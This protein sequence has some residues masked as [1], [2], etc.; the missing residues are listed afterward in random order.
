MF[1]TVKIQKMT[2]I[3]EKIPDKFDNIYLIPE[4]FTLAEAA[5]FR[6]L[7]IQLRAIIDDESKQKDFCGLPVIKTSDAAENFN[8]RTILIIL[9]QKP[10]PII[11][12]IF[13]LKAVG[14]VWTIPAFVM[15][16]E[17]T[18]PIYD[19][20]TLLKIV[21]QYEEDGI[22]KSGINFNE[23]AERF[24]RGLTTML[25]PHFQNF[26][27][28]LWDSNRYFK[29]TYTFDDT[30]IVIQG[31][32]VYENNYTAE[33]FKLYRSIYPNVPIIV[34]TWKDEATDDFRRECKEN[35]IV[36]L[37]NEPPKDRGYANLN[38]QLKSSLEGVKYVKESITAKFVLKT[39]SDQRIN[40]FEFL[41]HFKNLLKTFPPKDDKLRERI[42][43]LG[44]ETTKKF[45]FNFHDFLAFGHIEDI[46]K[47]YD[48]PFHGKIGKLSYFD[49]H[50]T[51]VNK[52]GNLLADSKPPFDYNVVTEQSH[53]LFKLNRAMNRIYWPEVYITRTFYEKYIAPIDTSKL[54]ETSWKFTVDYLIL[55]DF[56]TVLLDWFKY[57]YVRYIPK[58]AFEGSYAFSRWLDMYQNF[59]INWV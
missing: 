44:S 16:V 7:N 30:A 5:L 46:S 33:T 52:I 55:I 3:L 17:E 38:L 23:L 37:E 31:P 20:L 35:S 28:Q 11:Q 4:I 59:K 43:L 48:I 1:D 14:G 39:R 57:E 40:L 29:L 34:S 41:A 10:L 24:A 47:L 21:R 6:R 51:R 25:H 53:K 36:L 50:R 9:N 22:L 18:K 56:E 27:Y 45:P 15:S 19:R 49:R 26:K 8:E 2:A 42:I 32:L 13:N 12:T 54:F 58:F